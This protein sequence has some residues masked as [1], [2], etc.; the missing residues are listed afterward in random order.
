M[1]E[2]TITIN[3]RDYAVACED[4]QEPHL[5]RLAKMLESK[6]EELVGAMGQ[7]GDTRL[8]VM[9]GLLLAD[10]INDANRKL[11]QSVSKPSPPPA[12]ALS[13]TELAAMSK[14]AN[15]IRQAA[16]H[17]DGLAHKFDQD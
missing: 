14:L 1:S 8:L 9:A 7:V 16:S 12:A 13:D 5:R 4:G 17:I 11:A 6:V 10:D 3:K 15:E 2:V